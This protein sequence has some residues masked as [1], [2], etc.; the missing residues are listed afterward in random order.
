MQD[1]LFFDGV[2]ATTPPTVSTTVYAS[3]GASYRFGYSGSYAN[4]NNVAL[5]EAYFR[6]RIYNSHG[7]GANTIFCGFRN[8]AN[9]IAYLQVD[10]IMRWRFVVGTTVVATAAV[11]MELSAWYC[12]EVRIKIDAAVGRLVLKI[13]GNTVI[14]YTGDTT[15]SG[16]YAGFDNVYW[17]Y[18]GTNSYYIY[19]DDI[20]LND[21]TGAADNSWC[22]GGRVIKIT[23]DGNGSVNDWDGSDGNKVDNYL[24]VDEYPYNS[25]DYVYTDGTVPGTQ[26][27]YAMS[28]YSFTGKTITRIWAECRGKKNSADAASL[29]IGF[30]T[31]AS[32]NVDDAGTLYETY[33]SRLVGA[34]YTLNPDDAAAWEE[35]DIDALEFIAEVG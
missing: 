29:L 26:D 14:D 24:L 10:D 13:D 16:A 19:V 11:S 25:A 7:Y 34:E 28:H 35:A 21:T 32:E 18:S 22:G 3:G 6:Q 2:N 8:G 1:I 4:K 12:A 33:S 23:P 27:M 30:D 9:N 20:A 31:G 15:V 17:K 5:A